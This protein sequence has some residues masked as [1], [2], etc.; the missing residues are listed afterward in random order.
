MS[1]SDVRTVDHHTGGEP[2][3]IVAEP[4]V[5]IPGRTVADRRVLAVSDPAVDGLRRMP[6]F[7]P[8]GHADMYGGFITPPDDGGALFGVLFRHK[9]GFSTACGH[10]TIALGTWAVESGPVEADP[11]DELFPGFVLR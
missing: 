8:R 1:Q 4:P 7:E 6:C 9:D 5:A 10:G 3:R 11:A 2:F